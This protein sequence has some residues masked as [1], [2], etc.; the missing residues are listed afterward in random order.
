MADSQVI[1]PPARIKDISG[2]NFGMIT[3]VSFAGFSR[4]HK[5]LWIC[6]CQC[7]VSKS[8]LA[9]SL[10]IGR[11]KS[12]GCQRTPKRVTLPNDAIVDPTS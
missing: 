4:S 9:A 6:L 12:C 5:P 1:N 8:I 11:T 2:Q 10:L 7:G 3:V